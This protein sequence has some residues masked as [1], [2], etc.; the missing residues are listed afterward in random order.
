LCF[1]GYCYPELITMLYANSIP[2]IKQNFS[3]NNQITPK[4]LFFCILNSIK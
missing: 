3:F 4:K 2:K 1:R